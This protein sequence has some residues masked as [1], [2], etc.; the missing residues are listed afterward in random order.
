[1]TKILSCA[2]LLGLLLHRLPA[3]FRKVRAEL[4]PCPPDINSGTAAP[5]LSRDF[6]EPPASRQVNKCV[7]E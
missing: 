5:L 7:P 2:A 6:P 3:Y 4:L 1:M